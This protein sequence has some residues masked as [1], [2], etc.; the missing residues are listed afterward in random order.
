MTSS[1]RVGLVG[2]GALSKL[3]LRRDRIALPAVVYVITAAVAGTAYTFKKLYPTEASRAALAAAG[4]G[5]PAL[6]FLYGRL[7]GS[8]IGS[9]TTWRYGIWA[10]IFAALM[11]IFV[12]IRHTR[13]DEEA[14]RLELIDSAVAGLAGLRRRDIA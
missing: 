5:N 11:A 2:T 10:G 4:G 8:S 1:V 12:V 14:G 9:L 6:R 13:S 7:D 3:A